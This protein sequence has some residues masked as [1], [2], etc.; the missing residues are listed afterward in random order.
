MNLAHRRFCCHNLTDRAPEHST[1]SKNRHGRFRESELL[2]H[3]FET[4]VARCI[5]ERLVGGQRLAID[6]S[7]IEADAN[8]QNSKPKE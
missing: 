4:T 5:A 6:A 3:L 2:R 7:L 1:F 8:K